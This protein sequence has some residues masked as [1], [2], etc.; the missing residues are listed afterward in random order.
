MDPDVLVVE[1]VRAQTKRSTHLRESR[2]RKT[3]QTLANTKQF[4]KLFPAFLYL[5]AFLDLHHHIEHI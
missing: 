1:Q 2:G 5:S 4:Q 3:W